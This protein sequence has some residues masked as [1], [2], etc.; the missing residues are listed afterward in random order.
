MTPARLRQLEAFRAMLRA[1]SVGAAAELLSLSQ[2]AV[3]KLLRALEEETGLALFDRSRRRLSP[4][5]RRGASR[6]R[7]R[8]CSPP[9]GG[10]TSWPATCAPPAWASCAWPACRCSGRR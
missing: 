5:R 1:G 2:P 9:Q 4:R 7:W 8:R 6:R 10:W 3:T